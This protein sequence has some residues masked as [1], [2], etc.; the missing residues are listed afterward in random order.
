MEPEKFCL[1][2]NEYESNLGTALRDLRDSNDFFDLTLACDDAQEIQVHR[3]I[4]SACS[5]FFRNILRRLPHHHPLVY[6]RGIKLADLQSVVTFMY[7]GEVNVAQEDLN[8]FLILAEDLK[9]KGLTQCHGEAAAAMHKRGHLPAPKVAMTSVSCPPLKPAPLPLSRRSPSLS[10]QTNS[11]RHQQLPSSSVPR[12]AA[13]SSSNCVA[14]ANNINNI[15]T[16]SIKTEVTGREDEDISDSP[17][18]RSYRCSPDADL[19]TEPVHISSPHTDFALGVPPLT[20]G[21]TEGNKG[22][23]LK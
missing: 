18:R 22:M 10:S 13:T 15:D 3:V 16:I 20:I 7:H 23:Y 17:G 14:A 2:W 6:L 21:V 5:S 12:L 8:A 1:R 11:I 4:L 9:I 19:E